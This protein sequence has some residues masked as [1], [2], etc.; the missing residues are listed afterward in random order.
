MPGQKTAHL[1][2]LTLASAGTAAFDFFTCT[3]KA[4]KRMSPLASSP[5]C[6]SVPAI[7]ST[8]Y[9][10]HLLRLRIWS[11]VPPKV[12]I[13]RRPRPSA[14]PYLSYWLVNSHL[15]LPNRSRDP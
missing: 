7:S 8:E 4:E 2:L 6:P 13:P 12:R 15:A 14:L 11:R 3:W 5:A 9:H 1:E 10:H